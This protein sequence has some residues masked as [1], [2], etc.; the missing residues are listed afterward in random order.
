MGA[1]P[2]MGGAP[3]Q[4]AKGMPPG[5]F[6]KPQG[7]APGNFPAK[8]FAKP[9]MGAG[10]RLAPGA[11]PGARGPVPGMGNVQGGARPGPVQGRAPGNFPGGQ[12][13]QMGGDPTQAMYNRD[14][15]ELVKIM[16]LRKRIDHFKQMDGQKQRN[17]LG[18]I[19][20][21]VAKRFCKNAHN[22]PK[23][24]GMLIDVSVM[25]V[26]EIMDNLSK[27]PVIREKIIEAE[28]L[29]SSQQFTAKQMA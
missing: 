18:E 12:R 4:G 8:Q 20:F 24:T 29:I 28:Q 15:P 13:P 23:I 16:A 14:Y 21:P 27:L 25:T 2:N 5:G 3:A 19:L 1:G 11:Q 6:V 9:Q 22:A 10:Q 17:I 7:G 26:E